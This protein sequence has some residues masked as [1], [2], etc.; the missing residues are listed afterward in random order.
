[1]GLNDNDKISLY[2]LLVLDAACHPHVHYMYISYTGGKL[3]QTMGAQ[4]TKP[5]A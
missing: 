2:S 1:M 5:G 3:R 4:R